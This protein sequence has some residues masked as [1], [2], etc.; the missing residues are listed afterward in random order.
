MKLP[1]H[2]T[3]LRSMRDA[4]VKLLV[5][6]CPPLAASLDAGRYTFDLMDDSRAGVIEKVAIHAPMLWSLKLWT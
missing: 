3:L 4:R 1:K 5:P 6:R 2:P